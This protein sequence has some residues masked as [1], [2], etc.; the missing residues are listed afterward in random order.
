MFQIVPHPDNLPF[1]T[2][3]VDKKFSMTVEHSLFISEKF[4]FTDELK[5]LYDGVDDIGICLQTV[6]AKSVLTY[7]YFKQNLL[8]IVD[9]D[10]K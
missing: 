1:P 9:L 6:M 7:S 8:L 5:E 2:S 4:S 3:P 10:S